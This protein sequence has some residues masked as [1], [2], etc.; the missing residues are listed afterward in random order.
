MKSDDI[1]LNDEQSNK[2]I[3]NGEPYIDPTPGYIESIFEPEWPEW[4]RR[5]YWPV[6]H[7][8]IAPRPLEECIEN[9][10]ILTKGHPHFI[11]IRYYKQVAMQLILQSLDLY[12]A[13]APLTLWTLAAGDEFKIEEIAADYAETYTENMRQCFAPAMKEFQDRYVEILGRAF[14]MASCEVSAQAIAD[15]SSQRL[16]KPSDP[17]TGKKWDAIED[18]IKFWSKK[19]QIRLGV[20]RGRKKGTGV[21]PSREE[22][23]NFLLLCIFEC[24]S[25]KKKPRRQDAVDYLNEMNKKG[26]SNVPQCESVDKLDDW[27]KYYKIHW[28]Q[29][30]DENKNIPEEFPLYR[31]RLEKM[32][33]Y[34]KGLKRGK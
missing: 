19:Q 26:V 11:E 22:F 18:T 8:L 23:E 14:M 17:I 9:E 16:A 32:L 24:L 3:D 5:I 20:K 15:F 13:H 10:M 33:D 27:M 6:R 4:Y 31:E 12:L 2:N 7:S 29:L 30:V 1:L 25:K 34:L 28:S 21:F